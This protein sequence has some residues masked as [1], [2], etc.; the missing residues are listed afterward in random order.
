MPGISGVVGAGT[1]AVDALVDDLRWTGDERVQATRDDDLAVVVANHPSVA[2]PQ[3][4]SAGDVDVWLWGDIAGYEGDAG[5][6]RCRDRPAAFLASL[7]DRVGRSALADVNGLFAAVVRVGD[8][9]ELLTD[10]LGTCP[11]YYVRIDGGVVFSTH[12]QALDRHPAVT[13]GFDPGFVSEYLACKRPYGVRTPLTGVSQTQPSAVSVVDPDGDGTLPYGRYWRPVHRPLD[14]P[15][16]YFV[17][18]L[19]DRFERAVADRTSDRGRTGLLLSGGSDSR[20]VLAALDS[21]DRDA[22]LFHLN[23]WENTE[24]RVARESAAV[25]DQSFVFC[26]RDADYQA[27]ALERTP[28]MMNFVGYFNQ[29]HAA[30]FADAI[31]SRVDHLLTG[32]YG[33]VL[34]KGHHLPSTN[35]SLGPVGNVEVPVGS[36]DT[37]EEFVDHRAADAPP[38]L[39]GPEPRDVLA[40]NTHDRGEVIDHGVEYQSLREALLAGRCPLTNATSQFF[41]FGTT[42]TIPTTTP[43][44]DA[45]L[46]DLFLQIPTSLLRRGGLINAAVERLSPDLAAIPHGTTGQSLSRSYPAQ[47]AGRYLTAIKRRRADDPPVAHGTYGPWPDHGELVREHGFVHD[48]FE[49]NRDLFEALPFLDWGGAQ[50]LLRRQ[51]AGENQF[52]ALYSLASFLEMPVTRRLATDGRQRVG[53]D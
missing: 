26:R 42:Q 44:L 12:I 35:V 22:T 37:V 5:D 31:R 8:R 33:D 40:A 19:A 10:R 17:R 25:A 32:H 36:I 15:K 20:L 6:S 18:E 13:T 46:L 50:E 7:Y 29:A 4:A 28:A 38:F 30:G 21:L 27:R 14:R 34:F 51:E 53:A 48:C 45:R 41:Y 47:Y 39:D 23:E 52:G 16:S 49:R 9:V 1:Q 11:F 2:G 24:Y 43:F 3:P